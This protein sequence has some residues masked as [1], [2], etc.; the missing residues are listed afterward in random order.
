M[1]PSFWRVYT[2]DAGVERPALRFLLY[3][4]VTY[5]MCGLMDLF[6]GALRGMGVSQQFQC[7]CL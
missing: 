3:T 7:S 2:S 1:G 4:T 5:L 6:P